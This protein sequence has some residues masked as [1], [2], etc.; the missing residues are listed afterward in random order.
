M[1]GY[2]T[3][4]EHG[5]GAGCRDGNVVP[6]L[7]Q[8]DIAVFVFLD[9]FVSLATGEW[10]F[11]VPHVAVDFDVFDF[12]VGDRSFEMWVPIDQ[13]LAAIDQAFVVHLDK[14][15]QHGVVEVAGLF[16]CR[17]AFGPRHGK[18]RAG[19]VHAVAQAAR[20]L[21]DLPTLGGFPFPDLFEE[22]FTPQLCALG[23]LRLCKV[24]FNHQLGRDPGMIQSGLPESVIALHPLPS[25]EHVHD[26]V[27][28]GV[29]DVQ[30][31][32]HIGG[33]QHDAKGLITGC[34]CPCFEGTAVFPHFVNA[35]FGLG[36]VKCLFH[37]HVC[38][39]PALDA[40]DSG[41]G[42]EGKGL[43]IK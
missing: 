25:S 18:G 32:S 24:L 6:R 31:A 22:L 2:R 36:R 3:V 37:R 14:D 21:F 8:G 1:D 42:R 7:A 26:R 11:E 38:N 4:T 43:P 23:L 9:V 41:G 13:T 17:R 27:V 10:V 12:E 40:A 19:P 30:M 28:K 34:V 20:L 33:R 5:F 29:A 16:V 15:F 35:G 39:S